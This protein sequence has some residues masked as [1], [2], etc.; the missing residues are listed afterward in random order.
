MK[1]QFT[2]EIQIANIRTEVR[3]I[4]LVVWEIKIVAMI[5]RIFFAYQISKNFLIDNIQC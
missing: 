1:R 3:Y 2:E 4:S 5:D